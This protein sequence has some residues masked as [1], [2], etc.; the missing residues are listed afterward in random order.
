MVAA[1]V[2]V[3]GVGVLVLGALAESAGRAGRHNGRVR[4]PAVLAPLVCATTYRRGVHLLLGA[5]ILLP[6]LL[7]AAAFTRSLTVGRAP[8]PLTLLL[9]VVTVAIGALPAFLRGVR[10]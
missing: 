9:L 10:E 5:V 2:V 1:N 3:S 7:L 4:T 8:K 6:Y